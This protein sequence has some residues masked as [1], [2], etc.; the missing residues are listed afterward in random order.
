[1]DTQQSQDL[2]NCSRS[3]DLFSQD[4]FSQDLLS[5][6]AS[7][8]PQSLAESEEDFWPCWEKYCDPN[9]G[10]YNLPKVMYGIENIC[11][12]GTISISDVCA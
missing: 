5:Q 6:S 3:Q 10:L 2:S 11:V 4:L 12:L 7:Q 8:H 9:K 1:M